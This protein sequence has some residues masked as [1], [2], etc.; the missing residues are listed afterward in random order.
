MFITALVIIAKLWNQL[1][2]PSTDEWIRNDK[3]TEEGRWERVEEGGGG[4]NDP[5]NVS[6][7]E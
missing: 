1:R 7:C 2:C 5:N 3:E 6:T 4:R